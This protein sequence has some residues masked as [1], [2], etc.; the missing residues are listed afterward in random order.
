MYVIKV[1]EKD[2]GNVRW[3]ETHQTKERAYAELK[4]MQENH[5]NVDY[6]DFEVT[7]TASHK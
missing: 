5:F 1:I 4:H 3:T 7:K 2:S 6:F